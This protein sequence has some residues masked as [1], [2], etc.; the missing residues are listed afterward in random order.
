MNDHK[1]MRPCDRCGVIRKTHGSRDTTAP[2]RDC[3]HS[4]PGVNGAWATNAACTGMTD[5]G[6][7]FRPEITDAMR[8]RNWSTEPAQR[9][10]ATCPVDEACFTAAIQR[11]EHH[12]VWG[13]VLFEY[14]NAGGARY[15]QALTRRRLDFLTNI[16]KAGTT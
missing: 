3:M 10:C 8:S 14:G 12:G 9:I 2:C 7:F 5:T 13:G 15:T 11:R 6:L 1:D 16:K 4:R